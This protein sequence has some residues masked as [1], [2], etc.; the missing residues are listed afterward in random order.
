MFQTG[1]VLVVAVMVGFGLGANI[2]ASQAATQA[3]TNV[4][5]AP[6]QFVDAAPARHSA[7]MGGGGCGN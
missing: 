3:D 6:M 1:F 2:K 4:E 7:R 5:V